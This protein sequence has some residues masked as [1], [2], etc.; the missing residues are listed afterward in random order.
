MEEVKQNKTTLQS[1][2]NISPREAFNLSHLGAIILDIREEYYNQYKR[3]DAPEVYQIPLSRLKEENQ[4]LPIDKLIIVADTSGL[5]SKEAI[6]LLI[7]KGLSQLSNLAG[8]LV[9]WERSGLPIIIDN[10]ERMTGS[11]ACQL[12]QRDKR[13]IN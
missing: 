6:P 12:R 7:Q 8:G 5:K 13:K 10:S 1:I 9:E 3:F 2:P 4:K 11:C